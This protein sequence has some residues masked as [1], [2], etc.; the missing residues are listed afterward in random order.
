MGPLGHLFGHLDMPRSFLKRFGRSRLLKSSYFWLFI[1][2]PVALLLSKTGN[3]LTIPLGTGELV[4]PLGLPFSWKLF[5]FGAVSFSIGSL[6]YAVFCPALIREYDS[7]EEF[8]KSGK[9][10]DGLRSAFVAD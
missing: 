1:V 5:Y 4:I 7:Y 8:D 3:E 10:F 9:G 6:A 2:P